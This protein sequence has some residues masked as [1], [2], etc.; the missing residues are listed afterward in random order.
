MIF[1]ISTYSQDSFSQCIP[2]TVNCK[3]INDPGQICP[4]VLA[5]GMV[6]VEYEE[7]ITIIAPDS[8]SVAES[9][10]GLAK[11]ELESIENLPSGL[12]FQAET[13]EF[14]PDQAYCVSITGTPA[15]TGTFYLKIKVIPFISFFGNFV[16]LPAQTDST[17]VYLVI[18]P[19]S[20]VDQADHTDFVLINAYP[21]PFVSTTS[22]EYNMP[23]EGETELVIFNLLGKLIY[24]EK[25]MSVAGL[26]LIV[27]DGSSLQ[28]GYYLFAIIREQETLMGKL[29][30]SK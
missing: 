15:D 11:I 22:I 7:L 26:N 4:S 14:F 5:E 30:K 27:Y 12:E 20:S 13:T 24:R 19:S 28:A 1:L 25:K 16:A 18:K 29:F 8:A 10:I 21:N 17:S 2:D 6:G 9:M 3:D 23:S